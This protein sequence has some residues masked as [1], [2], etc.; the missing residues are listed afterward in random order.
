MQVHVRKFGA[1]VEFDDSE[2]FSQDEEIAAMAAELPK[3]E[4]VVAS[5][6][7]HGLSPILDSDEDFDDFDVSAFV[8][9]TYQ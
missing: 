5:R 3:F 2:L 4:R 9:R 8:G 7:L 1:E 6:P